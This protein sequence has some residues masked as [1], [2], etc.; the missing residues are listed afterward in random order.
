MKKESAVT[1]NG[2]PIDYS[3]LP[4]HMQDGMQM[5]IEYRIEPGSFLTA[6]LENDLMGALGKADDINKHR[7]YDY[8]LWLYNEAPAGC[9]GSVE[10]VREWLGG[11][12][13]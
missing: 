3:P 13:V 12:K 6:V 1:V 2:R 5:Y 10:A 8:G 4:E 7:L 11:R 9:F